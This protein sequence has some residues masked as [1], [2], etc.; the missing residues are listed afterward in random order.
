MRLYD[1]LHRVVEDCGFADLFPAG[2]RPTEAP[3]RLALATLPQVMEGLT[4]GKPP[5]QFARGSRGD[6]CYAWN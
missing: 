2:G 3:V 5:T 1:D 6:I 4:I